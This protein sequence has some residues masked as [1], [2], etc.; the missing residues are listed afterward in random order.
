MV[1]NRDEKRGDDEIKTQ[2]YYSKLILLIDI[3]K[4]LQASPY[5]EEEIAIRDVTSHV[6]KSSYLE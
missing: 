3:L 1:R 5:I 6:T 2:R 4:R